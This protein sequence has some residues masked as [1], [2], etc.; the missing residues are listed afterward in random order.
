MSDISAGSQIF[1]L[2]FHPSHS[3]VYTA[4]LSGKV[5]AFAYDQE[6]RNKQVLS[7]RVS[8][9]SCRGL[10]INEDG[11]RIYAVGKGK[12]LHTIDTETGKIVETRAKAHDVAINRV[13]NVT[14][15]LLSTGDDDGVVKLWDPRK[16]DAVRKYT[17]HFD[18]ITDFLWLED[19]KQLVATSGDGTLSVMDVRARTTEP[20]AQSEDQ[21]DELLSIAPIKGVDHGHNADWDFLSSAT[22]F[23]VGTQLGILSVFNR[24]SGWG[25]CV[26]RIPGHPQ[27]ID[28]LC[29]LPA[30]LP[31]VD[32]TSTILSGSSDGFVRAVGVFP[33]KLHG[34]VADHGEWPVERIA[35]GEGMSQLTLDLEEGVEEK[36]VSS[37]RQKSEELDDDA[38]PPG[39][40]WAGSAGHD[41]LLKLTNL[42]VFF[43]GQASRL[44]ADEREDS[45]ED[46]H[47]EEA[48]PS[49]NLGRL[50]ASDVGDKGSDSDSDD[51]DPEPELS[52]RRKRK[53]KEKDPLASKRKRGKNELEVEGAFFG[54]L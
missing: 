15:W 30:T 31:N 10:T 35:V 19:K 42:E 28:A 45:G 38:R 1:D 54:E 14:S 41:A 6:G 17:Q 51:P 8:H 20:F 25:D 5:K 40:F 36:S 16:K 32:C 9:K 21:E 7:I 44:G 18:Y 50:P 27:S 13:K 22:K 34:V 33:T 52:G 2:I 47:I 46:E 3:T 23:L 43:S 4:L 24:S 12:C 48:S 37:A 49:R 29:S 53:K 11:T 26:D 39:N